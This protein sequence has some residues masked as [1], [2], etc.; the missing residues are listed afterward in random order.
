MPDQSARPS[1]SVYKDYYQLS[2]TASDTNGDDYKTIASV[3][4]DI[5]EELPAPVDMDDEMLL[6]YIDQLK[7][8]IAALEAQSDDET[9]MNDAYKEEIAEILTE[10]RAQYETACDDPRA[11][12]PVENIQSGDTS[13]T[14]SD[15]NWMLI[16][17]IVG[18]IIFVALAL[19]LMMFRREGESNLHGTEAA[20]TQNTLP[21]HDTVAN[22]MYGGAA[23]IFQQPLQ[24]P[25]VQPM[26]QPVVQPVA[27]GPPLP[28][29][30]LPA[31][32]TMEQWQYYGQQYLD[33]LQQ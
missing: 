17:G 16:L 24:Q 12:C 3:K 21:I 6:S 9:I 25:A 11:D 2:I 14:S 10:K 31:G 5:L 29:G 4:W 20:W 1:G 19:G 28:P 27:A 7:E 23:P 18:G 22:S 32:W 8:E 30:G 13:E 15:T 33:R 26:P